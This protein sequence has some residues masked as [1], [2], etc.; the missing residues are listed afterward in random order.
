MADRPTNQLISEKKI[1]EKEVTIQ[2]LIESEATWKRKFN[3]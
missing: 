1:Q 3:E 2:K